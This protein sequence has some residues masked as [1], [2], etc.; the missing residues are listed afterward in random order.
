MG[1]TFA[2]MSMSLDGFI[3]GPN[4]E[5]GKGRGDA[6]DRLHAWMFVGK[7]DEG[8]GAFLG[9]QFA[10]VGAVVMGRTM[11]DVGIDPWGE[12]PS[13]HA[14]VFVVPHRPADPIVKR[15]GTSYAFVTGG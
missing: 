4:G 6:G 3:A 10:S 11:L 5:V 9:A 1:R 14:P 15:G 8:I 7:A 12:E 2:N 13:F